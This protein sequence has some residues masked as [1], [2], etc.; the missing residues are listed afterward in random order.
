MSNLKRVLYN[1]LVVGVPYILIK[2]VNPIGKYSII[3]RGYGKEV[4]PQFKEYHND[5]SAFFGD[6]EPPSLLYMNLSS[7]EWLYF[8][9][10]D[11]NTVDNYTKIHKMKNQI[12]DGFIMVE[13]EVEVR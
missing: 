5:K 1:E 3:F 13:S 4:Y 10:T 6:E 9:D 2:K 8:I 7:D 11:T 12:Y